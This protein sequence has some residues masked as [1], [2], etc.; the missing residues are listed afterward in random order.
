MGHEAT[1]VGLSLSLDTRTGGVRLDIV[2]EVPLGAVLVVPIMAHLQGLLLDELHSN[3]LV[4]GVISRLRELGVIGGPNPVEGD[5]GRDQAG[6]QSRLGTGL[7]CVLVRLDRSQLQVAEPVVVQ[8]VPKG[9]L[10]SA[11]QNGLHP[12]PVGHVPLFHLVDVDP[13][14]LRLPPVLVRVPVGVR[15]QPGYHTMLGSEFFDLNTGIEWHVQRESYIIV[16]VFSVG[17]DVESQLNGV[18]GIV[19]QPHGVSHGQEVRIGEISRI[20]RDGHDLERLSLIEAKDLQNRGRD[21]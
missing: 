7:E 11:R 15:P 12:L 13:L 3:I 9:C 16:L 10:F 6:E 21:S 17:N 1:Q 4:V 14:L 20:P 2:D 19:S 18:H 5:G 8:L